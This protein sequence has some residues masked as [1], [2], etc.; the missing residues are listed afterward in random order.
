MNAEAD[1]RRLVLGPDGRCGGMCECC[2][3]ERANQ[4]H[5]RWKQ[6]QGG[7]WSASNC[8]GVGP[9][10]HHLIEHNVPNSKRWGWWLEPPAGA[11]ARIPNYPALRPVR[12][13][14][15]GWV[16]LQDDGGHWPHR[17]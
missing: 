10:C 12:L 15:L 16:Y 17:D 5:H 3:T 4:L 9:R 2:F 7:P 11:A 1:T 8:L 6:G 14:R 13:S